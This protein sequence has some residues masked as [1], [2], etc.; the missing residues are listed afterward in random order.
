VANAW[1][2]LCIET[3]LSIRAAAAAAWIARL[4]CRGVI[5]SVGSRPGNNQPLGSILPS[6]WATRHQARN[7]SSS[8]GESMA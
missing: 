2:R 4:S 1:R 3:G 5:G 7:R 8:T 6:A